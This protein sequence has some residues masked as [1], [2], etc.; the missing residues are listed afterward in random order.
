MS[1]REMRYEAEI[2]PAPT[3][4]GW[5]IRINEWATFGDGGPTEPLLWGGTPWL[6][7][8]TRGWAE[9]AARRRLR[10]L[11]ASRRRATSSATRA[12]RV[13]R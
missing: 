9:R 2:R 5:Q 12:Y 6:W 11:D 13:A 10:N 7:Y 4:V 8:M 1:E 3:G